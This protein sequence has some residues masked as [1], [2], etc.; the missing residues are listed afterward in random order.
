MRKSDGFWL[1]QRYPID[2]TI[3]VGMSLHR[4]LGSTNGIICGM[5]PN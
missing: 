2:V 1:R 3:A 5:I 4:N